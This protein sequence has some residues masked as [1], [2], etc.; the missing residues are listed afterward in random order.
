M[1]LKQQKGAAS[2]SKRNV[3]TPPDPSH[4]FFNRKDLTRETEAKPASGEKNLYFLG[5]LSA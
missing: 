1:L 5:L 2:D 3:S 4:M